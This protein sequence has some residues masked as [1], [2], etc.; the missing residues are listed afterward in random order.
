MAMMRDKSA[1]KFKKA[2]I[3]FGVVYFVSPIELLPD[4]LLPFGYIDDIVFWAALL[5]YLNDTLKK[6]S[7][8][9]KPKDYS[10]KYKNTIDDVEFEV[11]EETVVDE[12]FDSEKKG[13]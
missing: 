4:F 11:K 7:G 5:Y 12:H 10:K 9:Q 13:E 3:I 1:S 2:L 8:T 6:Y